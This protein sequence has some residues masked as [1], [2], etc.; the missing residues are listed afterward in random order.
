MNPLEIRWL[1]PWFFR[2]TFSQVYYTNESKFKNLSTKNAKS[3]SLRN[4]SNTYDMP[5]TIRF[6][7]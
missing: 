1:R 5:V 7:E 6:Q 3:R 4:L 2:L